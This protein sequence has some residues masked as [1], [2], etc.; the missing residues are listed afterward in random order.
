M[1]DT[2]PRSV[3]NPLASPQRSKIGW[4]EGT[5]TGLILVPIR[6]STPIW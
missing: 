1:D 3:R 2:D 4:Q 5:S 6:L